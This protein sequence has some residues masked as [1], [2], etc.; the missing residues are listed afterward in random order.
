[1]FKTIFLAIA[2]AFI[3]SYCS[4]RNPSTATFN[5]Y[6]WYPDNP[7]QQYLGTTQGLDQCGSVASNFAVSKNL[8]RSDGWN[9]IC[10][11]KTNDSECAEKHR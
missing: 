9:Y 11:L 6:F 8:S 2:V 5:V 1:M 3:F 10:C 4:E 7:N